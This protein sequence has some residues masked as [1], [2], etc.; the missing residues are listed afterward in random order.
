[1]TSHKNFHAWTRAHVSYDDYTVD[2]LNSGERYWKDLLLKSPHGQLLTSNSLFSELQKKEVNLLHI[3][4]RMDEILS[5]KSLYS[6]GGCLVGSVYCTPLYSRGNKLYLSN[7]GDYILNHES[8]MVLAECPNKNKI[9]TPLIIKV[10]NNRRSNTSILGVDYTKLGNIHFDIYTELKYLLSKDEQFNLENDVVERIKKSIKFLRLC[11]TKPGKIFSISPEEFINELVKTIDSLPYMGY[12]YF[13]VVSEYLMLFSCDHKSNECHRNGELNNYNYKNVA[14]ILCPNL[15]DNFNLGT[16]K[17]N[18][19]DID[20]LIKKLDKKGEVKIDFQ[21]FSDWL[22]KRISYLVV[23]D[24]CTNPSSNIDWADLVW[25]YSSLAEYFRPLMGHII[26]RLLRNF[27]RFEDFYY[28]F[29][30]TKALQVWN[31]WNY[32]DILF[33]FN[34][35][36]PKGEVGIN[37]AQN[38]LKYEI[39]LG[40]Y[41]PHDNTIKPEKLLDVDIPPRM[42]DFKNSFRRNKPS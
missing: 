2:P 16:F 17:P 13:E 7:L 21:H 36:I 23:K 26:H 28:Y 15:L 6:S 18:L 32:Q 10:K 5:T 4:N 12:V 24:L 29:D 8:K 41:D 19:K 30:Q 22:M 25:E 27:N 20:K 37:P 3:T 14:F 40:S 11:K 35:I 34:G 33:P 31:Y 39:W 1:M 9:I 42:V 38:N